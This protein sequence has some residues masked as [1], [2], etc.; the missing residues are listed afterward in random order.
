MNEMERILM[1]TMHERAQDMPAEVPVDGAVVD[2][3]NRRRTMKL[4]GIGAVGLA[5]VVAVTAVGIS[6]FGNDR[7]KSGRIA[8]QPTTTT[9]AP[10]STTPA[11]NT[12][13]VTPTRPR[14]WRAL[15]D[16]PISVSETA[17]WTGRE[18]IIDDTGCCAD[19][20]T[21]RYAAYDPA[22]D[23]W[24]DL[25][26]LP[27]GPRLEEGV[28]FAD[29]SLF[30]AGGRTTNTSDEQAFALDSWRYDLAANTW[31]KAST[32]PAPVFGRAWNGTEMFF[33][34][35]NGDNSLTYAYNPRTDSWRRLPDAPLGTRGGPTVIALGEKVAV[36]GGNDGS[37]VGG[38]Q[39]YR[40]F[41]DG[42][43]YD[44]ATNNWSVIPAAPVPARIDQ[45]AV[46]TGAE[47]VV[48]GGHDADTF[49]GH[50][51]AYDP[52]TNTWRKIASS[53]L[54]A[55]SQHL[56]LW[57]GEEMLV[58][59]GSSRSY[60]AV[61][62]SDQDFTNGAAYNPR[63]DTWRALPV[64]PDRRVQMWKAAWIGDQAVFFGGVAFDANG[65]QVNG[66]GPQ[67]AS[68]TPIALVP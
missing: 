32:A 23:A 13:A 59:G 27:D 25:A 18:L 50:G 6:V 46:W 51:A 30:V 10:S 62:G 2:R 7:D 43:L 8:T 57:T 53:P 49:Y 24:R 66:A 48:W 9:A 31:T 55:R 36:W 42:A 67:G 33:A 68:M 63:T 52:V 38:D 56:A 28:A 21:D 45:T 17:V 37:P 58:V 60:F 22:A 41:N 47:M 29:G 40:S 3:A 5:A 12:T 16:A 64:P 20:G 19:P 4:A 35:A 44:P 11:P 65:E 39:K 1:D 14:G 61:S 34:E 54:E 26:P 15:A